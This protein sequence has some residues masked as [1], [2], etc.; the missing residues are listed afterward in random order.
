M[1]HASPWTHILKG[2]PANEAAAASVAQA[3]L[4]PRSAAQLSSFIAGQVQMQAHL[5]G[6]QIS[7]AFV[8]RKASMDKD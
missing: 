5:G 3:I 6:P 1:D 8:G 4:G 2:K 7:K